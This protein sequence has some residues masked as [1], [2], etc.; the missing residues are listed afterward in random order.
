[1]RCS[2]DDVLRPQ[3]IAMAHAVSADWS[4]DRVRR[5]QIGDTGSVLCLFCPR[6]FPGAGRQVLFSK[7]DRRHLPQVEMPGEVVT[8][9]ER[10]SRVE[11]VSA[12]LQERGFDQIADPGMA[13]MCEIIAASVPVRRMQLDSPLLLPGLGTP[14]SPGVPGLRGWRSGSNP[15]PAAT[16]RPCRWL[17][18]AAAQS[19]AVRPDGRS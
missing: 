18:T 17:R 16:C 4:C 14:R 5:F 19:T 1:M 9:F 2:H 3:G 7:A 10:P 8:P 13:D 6:H 15:L 12:S 11:R